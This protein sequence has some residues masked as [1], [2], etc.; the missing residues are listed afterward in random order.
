MSND[1]NGWWD[2]EEELLNDHETVV[3]SMIGSGDSGINAIKEILRID[4]GVVVVSEKVTVPHASDMVY[5]LCNEP[6]LEWFYDKTPRRSG[7][8]KNKWRH[9]L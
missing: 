8:K 1:K 5:E 2:T 6:C 9:K 4:P 7:Q 3:V